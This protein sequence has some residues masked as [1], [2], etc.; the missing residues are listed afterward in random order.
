M[1]EAAAAAHGVFLQRAQAGRGLARA[2]DAHFVP[3]ACFDI[4]R[5]E[6]G[7]AGE[8]AEEI[9]R[10]A[11]GRQHGACG[12]GD[13]QHLHALG[14]LDAV[15][16]IG[17]DADVGRQLPEGSTASGRPA[18]TPAWRATSVARAC[19][20]SGMVATEVMSPARPRSSSSAWRTAL[21]TAIG[22]RNASGCRRE[23][24][25]IMADRQLWRGGARR[26]C[27]AQA[28]LRRARLGERHNVRWPRA[29]SAG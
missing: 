29:F 28:I 26:A 12:A 23:A 11:L 24:G 9:Q 25:V 4:G 15:A 14:D 18:I 2:A 17:L 16:R 20:A 6:R 19:V 13:R 7:D 8:M 1:V 10:D 5:R 21:S 3:A 22:D 27:L